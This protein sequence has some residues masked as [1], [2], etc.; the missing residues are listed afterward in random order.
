MLNAAG[1]PHPFAEDRVIG[2]G[3]AVTRIDAM[4]ERGAGVVGAH[5][6]PVDVRH[7]VIDPYKWP[8]RCPLDKGPGLEVQPNPLSHLI[9]RRK[10]DHRQVR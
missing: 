2:I 8:A 10:D 4:Q 6:F 9:I 7:L 1:F 5:P 3:K